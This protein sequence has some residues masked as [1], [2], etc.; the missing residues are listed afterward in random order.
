MNIQF[1]AQ[2][3]LV[4]SASFF[5]FAIVWLPFS[6]YF[7]GSSEEVTTHRL[8]L[9]ATQKNALFLV[10]CFYSRLLYEETSSTL[11]TQAPLS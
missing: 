5:R 6:L 1:V 10:S 8:R 7:Y 2:R 11:S 9:Q 4:S 3:L